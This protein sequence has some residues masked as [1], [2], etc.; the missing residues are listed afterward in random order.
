MQLQ[1]LDKREKLERKI[2]KIIIHCSDSD[3]PEHDNAHT[4]HQWHLE[5]GFI[6]IG[7]HYFI[8]KNGD[9]EIGRDEDE[10]GAHCKGYNSES[11]G[12]CVSGRHGFTEEQFQILAALVTRVLDRYKLSPK[13]IFLHNELDRHKTCPNFSK[14]EILDRLYGPFFR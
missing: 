3:R 10:V 5:R 13:N 11:I 7:Y 4:I 1:K 2:T 6:K 9:L 8:R 12:I 14:K